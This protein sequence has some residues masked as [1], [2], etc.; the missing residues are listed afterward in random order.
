MNT[1]RLSGSSSRC[2]RDVPAALCEAASPACYD[3]LYRRAVRV[4]MGTVFQ[5]PWTRIGELDVPNRPL[6]GLPPQLAQMTEGVEGHSARCRH[7]QGIHAVGHGDAHGVVAT[8]DSGRGVAFLMWNCTYPLVIWKP[9]RHTTLAG[10]VLAQQVVGFC[11][12][13]SAK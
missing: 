4:S 2:A 1:G 10:V 3:P 11:A 7:V 6:H 5:V 8:V 13:N 12:V 9:Q